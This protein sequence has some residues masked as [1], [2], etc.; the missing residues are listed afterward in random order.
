[1]AEIAD[2]LIHEATGLSQGH[3]SASQ[4]GKTAKQAKAKNLYLIHY[5]TGVNSTQNLIPEAKKQ[6]DGFVHLA[7]DFLT[8]DL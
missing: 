7:E 8:F 6:F 4:A 5:P 3:S 2:V 1:L